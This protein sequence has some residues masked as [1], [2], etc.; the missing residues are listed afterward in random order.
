MGETL[1]EHLQ[2]RLQARDLLLLLPD[3]VLEAQLALQL[4][5]G[6]FPSGKPRSLSLPV[7]LSWMPSRREGKGR[8][9]NQSNHRLASTCVAWLY[10]EISQMLFMSLHVGS[11]QS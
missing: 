4:S 2:A 8:E 3:A 1:F 7:V 5:L 6:G 9:V 11:G 10:L